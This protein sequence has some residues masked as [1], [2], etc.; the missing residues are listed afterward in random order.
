MTGPLPPAPA[1]P[2]RL[3]YFGTPRM[4]VPTLEALVA[5]GFDVALVVTRIDKRRGRGNDLMPSPVKASAAQLGLPVSHRVDDATE[6]GADLGVVVA[7]GQL[8]ARPVL[9]QLPMVNLHFSLLPRWR[10]AAPVERAILA[11]DTHTGVGVMRVE[12]GLDTGGLYAQAVVAVDDRSAAELRDELVTLGTALLLGALR[13]GLAEPVPQAGEPLYARKIDPAELQIDWTRSA[14][15]IARLVRLGMAW[16]TFR[17][18]RL[19][20]LD[21]VVASADVGRSPGQVIERSVATGEGSLDLVI[22][23]PEGKAAMAAQ[24]WINGARPGPEDRLGG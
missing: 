5:A 8:I 3:V 15:E 9:E 7:F 6:V 14:V 10:G 17:S 23:Q 12:E 13:Q 19:K 2:R 20:V 21:A 1:H 18:R 4:A 24:A 22:V 11:G 16:T